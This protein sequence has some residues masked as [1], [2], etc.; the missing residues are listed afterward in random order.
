MER[1]REVGRPGPLKKRAA[2]VVFSVL[3]VLAMVSSASAKPSPAAMIDLPVGSTV[4]A[5]GDSLTYG[6]DTSSSGGQAPINGAAERR[7]V[8]PYPE[9]LQLLFKD[10]VR[11]INHGYPGDRTVDGLVRWQNDPTASLVIIMYGT[12]DTGDFRP[13]GEGKLTP[14][15]YQQ[16]MLDLIHR[17]QQRGAKVIVMSPPPARDA[18]IEATI[19]P[20]RLAAHAAAVDAGAVFL[21]LPD[22]VRPVVEPWTDGL[23]LTPAGYRAIALALSQMIALR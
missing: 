5:E 8:T 2:G 14:S 19:V 13:G 23:H 12:N 20:Y 3:V 10:K 15:T 9:T 11:V 6:H 18:P 21:D 16:V 7:S 22:V 17:S 1:T 4:I